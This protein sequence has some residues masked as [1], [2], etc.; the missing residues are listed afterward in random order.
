MAI[1]QKVMLVTELAL[2]ALFA[3][4]IFFHMFAFG[5]LYMRHIVGLESILILIN[6]GLLLALR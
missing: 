4:D 2:L 5:C 1:G 3:L 6:T